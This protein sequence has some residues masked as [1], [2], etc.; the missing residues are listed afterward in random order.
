MYTPI[1]IALFLGSAVV[2]DDS[3]SAEDVAARTF[4]QTAH[5]IVYRNDGQLEGG[6][7]LKTYTSK[8]LPFGFINP[9]FTTATAAEKTADGAETP[10][11]FLPAF[12][13]GS[14]FFKTADD[15]S[16]EKLE[17][18]ISAPAISPFGF[19]PLFSFDDDDAVEVV[20]DVDA[21]EDAAVVVETPAEKSAAEPAAEEA[22]PAADI[23][24][25]VEPE[26]GSSVIHHPGFYS[27]AF[28]SPLIIPSSFSLP[29]YYHSSSSFG[30]P[31]PVY[32]SGAHGFPFIQP[33]QYVLA[34]VDDSAE[35][36]S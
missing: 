4:H 36:S 18:S 32:Y 13:Y 3:S 10:A 35:D 34:K 27:S 5:S 14:P 23:T 25:V 19:Q 7:V 20:A 31:A 17:F 22:A 33:H 12:T 29:R 26:F 9:L 1:F 21:A 8:A 24:E 15:E 6:E 2:A 30:L 28:S 11:S 16:G